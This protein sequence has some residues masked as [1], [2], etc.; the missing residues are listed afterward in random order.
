[1]LIFLYTYLPSSQQLK[2]LLVHSGYHVPS[3]VSLRWRWGSSSQSGFKINK[4]RTSLQFASRSGKILA[5]YGVRVTRVII[6]FA[7]YRPWIQYR[8]AL[9]HDARSEPDKRPTLKHELWRTANLLQ[10]TNLFL[11][12][13]FL[14]QELSE[15][16][17]KNSDS[18]SQDRVSCF[19][20]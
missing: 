17:K 20:N 14:K 7:T 11:Q 16:G 10:E 8:G 4:N 5:N 13:I 1:M 9:R 2:C 3:S 15:E 12:L 18:I 6:T 19:T